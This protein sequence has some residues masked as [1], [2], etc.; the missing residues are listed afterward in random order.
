M[1]PARYKC[2]DCA[3]A[4]LLS[5]G[6]DYWCSSCQ[7]WKDAANVDP[8]MSDAVRAAILVSAAVERAVSNGKI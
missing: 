7:E 6:G 5:N 8:T 3:H 4:L 2:P 1:K